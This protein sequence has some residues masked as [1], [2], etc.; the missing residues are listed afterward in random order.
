[1]ATSKKIENCSQSAL[2]RA[3]EFRKKPRH[4][5]PSH[6][7]HAFVLMNEP[8]LMVRESSGTED[9]AEAEAFLVRLKVD[10]YRDSHLGIKQKRTW[11]EAVVRYLSVKA[12]IRSAENYRGICRKLDP[13]LGRLTLDQIDADVIW[14]LCEREQKKGRRPATI[15][16]C[17]AQIRA[18][19]RM[20]YH[21]WQW[22]DRL[23]RV[24][25]LPGDRSSA[26]VRYARCESYLSIDRRFRQ[27]RCAIRFLSER[28]CLCRS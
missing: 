22:L 14:N 23:P 25:L 3:P 26:L 10:A 7:C 12:S 28:A 9:R 8:A 13:Y 17:L 11:Q 19:L 1:M 24:R 16:R 4:E 6:R 27:I 5:A 21:D 20:A 18:L 15:N 2:L